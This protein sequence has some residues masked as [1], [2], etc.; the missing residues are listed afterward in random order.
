[1]AHRHPDTTT[2]PARAANA[3]SASAMADAANT[4]TSS[5]KE[6]M[7]RKAQALAEKCFL[8]GNVHG[9]RQW[10]QSAVRL[11]PALPGT[12]Q[13]VAAYDVHAAAA[14]RRAPDCWYAVLG[15]HQQQQPGGAGAGVTHD[16]VKRQHRRLCLLVHPD[17][18][19][20]AAADGAFKL[21]QAAWHALSARHPPGAAAAPAPSQPPPW[22]PKRQQAAPARAPEPQP[23]PRP[24]VVQMQRRAPAPA[25]AAAAP[26]MPSYAQRASRNKPPEKTSAPPPPP[27]TGRRPVSPIGDKCPS[28]GARTTN[29]GTRFRCFS[30]EWSP[31]D[32][33]PDDDD[34]FG[35]YYY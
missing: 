8:A 33:R 31:M 23:R 6:E 9:A 18:N 27:P 26:T 17:K 21:V 12:A 32:D 10:M 29:G 35:D 24:Q 4:S 19:P 5:S 13:I 14:G 20:C 34:L 3:A 28:C 16:D 1:M 11:A 30:C 7:A 2:D 25:A 22:P 15:L